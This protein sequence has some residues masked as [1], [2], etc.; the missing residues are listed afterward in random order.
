MH[1]FL[2]NFH[3]GGKYSSQI[4]SYQAELRWEGKFTDQKY[5]YNTSLYTDYLNGDISSGSGKNNERAN[6]VHKKYTPCGGANHSAEN[7]CKK[8]R[9]DKE[10]LV[11]LVIGK[12]S[13]LSIHLR[14]VLDTD[15]KIILLLN[16]QN[17]LQ[18]TRNGKNMSV[19]VKGIIVHWK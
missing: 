19:S 10:K 9:K 18:I 4:A 3:Q 14:N 11:R 1:I 12:T 7:C 5:L 6:I 15:L 2:D 13:R 8:I 16:V 17:Q